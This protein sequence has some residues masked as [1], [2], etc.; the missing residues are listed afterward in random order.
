[1]ENRL[2]LCKEQLKKID[3]KFFLNE[4]L[5]AIKYISIF[6]TKIQDSRLEQI[7]YLPKLEIGEVISSLKIEGIHTKIENYYQEQLFSDGSNLDYQEMNNHMIALQ[8]GTWLSMVYGF[9]NDVIK[10]I[11]KILF[12][13][14]NSIKQ[15]I[16]IGDYKRVNNYIGRDNIKIYTPPT[17]EETQMYMDDLI[18]F[19]ND[20]SI[21][22]HPLIKCAIIHAQ[23]ESIHPFEDGN[24]RIGRLLIPI[25]LCK[26]SLLDAPL[27]YIS[28]AIEK[29]KYLYYNSLTQT[30]GGNYNEWIKYFLK[31]C[32]IQSQKHI[33]LMD[34]IDKLY[35]KTTQE[36]EKITNSVVFP[37][38]V[39]SIF[40]NP[41]ISS[42]KMAD[43]LKVS[44]SQA[45]RYLRCLEEAKI[46]YKDD[47]KRN[48]IYY[49]GELLDMIS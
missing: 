28:E 36:I 13:N 42:K 2:P 9:T 27:F 25:Y 32:I 8:K 1:M 10:E 35:A 17:F 30:R 22:V 38:L 43:N 26:S 47:K 39:K 21:D 40:I 6:E 41:I 29:D 19:M 11:H 48:I 5:E 37:K 4:L 46:L 33:E 20:N 14:V 24:G 3:V 7:V 23:F 12:S 18:A 31:K 15:G 45:N 34:K 44:I 16:L 49:F